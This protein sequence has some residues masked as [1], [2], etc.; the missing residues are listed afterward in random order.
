V[1]WYCVYTGSAA[2]VERRRAGLVL[3]VTA[4]MGP[5]VSGLAAAAMGY[6][7]ASAANTAGLIAALGQ[8]A[9]ELA[10]DM[11]PVNVTHTTSIAN[12]KG[13]ASL[14]IRPDP[15]GT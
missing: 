6:A 1:S 4:A 13:Q 3:A 15:N 12:Y 11:K 2:W 9:V 14:F 7:I 5:G 10:I 8:A